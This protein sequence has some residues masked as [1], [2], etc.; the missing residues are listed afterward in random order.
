MNAEAYALQAENEQLRERLS[1]FAQA[2]EAIRNG[3]VDALVNGS[4]VFVLES[5]ETASNRFR[6]QVLEQIDD[7]VVAVDLEDR[8]TY[9]NP[10][11]E[12]KY[13]CKASKVLGCPL[14][15]LYSPVWVRAEDEAK[16]K[17]ALAEH[18]AWRGEQVHLKGNG[19]RLTVEAT[20]SVLRNGEGEVVGRLGVMRD[21]G[22]RLLSQ[23]ALEEAGRQK[24][25]FLATLA[26]E[27]RNPLSPIMN[28]LQLL[29][30]AQDDPRTMMTTRSMMQRQLDHMVR[31]VDD[32]MDV[33]RI[34][35]GKLELR[36][37]TI[38][39]HHTLV[40]AVEA[41][42]PMIEQSG[43]T[44]VQHVAEHPLWVE[45]DTNRLMQVIS[46]LLT[47]A[48]KYTEPGG[49]IDLYAEADGKHAVV[50]VKDNGIGLS[51]EDHQRIFEMFAQVKG[52]TLGSG[53]GIGLNI[54]QR[55]AHL[56]NG[57]LEVKSEGL[58]QGSEFALR[59][60]LV[61][62]TPAMV[63]QESAAANGN[64]HTAHRI[65]VVDDNRDGATTLAAIL[66]KSG[67]RVEIAFSGEQALEVGRSL[68]PELVFM[69]IGM[70]EMSGHETCQR[71]RLEDW[72]EG[73]RI[74]ALSGWGQQQ[75]MERSKQ[76]GFDEHLV[77]PI[78]SATVRRLADALDLQGRERLDGMEAR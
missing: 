42:M 31:L 21:I 23:R 49:R 74:I 26:H 25:H 72:G 45:A 63:K 68:R 10:A 17:K 67:H 52:K 24:D 16:A 5:A 70:P 50:R 44:L 14:R 12:Q 59:L 56:H 37:R 43:H 4:S 7:V 36:K 73:I 54:A 47:N 39:L 77:K 1:E 75:D 53:L 19:A 3:E 58:G 69:D 61:H 76:S 60:P 27:L 2:L 71:M 13:G 48:A 66:R 18:D 32:L 46:N 11:A 20:L 15:D 28:G 29:E 51:P 8:I 57:T 55:L 40:M 41:A 6:G 9:I 38:D 78:A 65:L 35:R 30:F 64:N 22:E 62:R 34:N 33:S